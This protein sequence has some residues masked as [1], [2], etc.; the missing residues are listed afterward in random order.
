MWRVRVTCFLASAILIF[1][2]AQPVA[3][4]ASPLATPDE[5]GPVSAI[6]LDRDGNG[7]FSTSLSDYLNIMRLEKGAPPYLT[8]GD[9]ANKDRFITRMVMTADGNDG[10]AIGV[11]DTAKHPLLWR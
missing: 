5:Y 4:H 10:W 6:V 9:P 1:P 2:Q 7:W 8:Y 3:L 11:D